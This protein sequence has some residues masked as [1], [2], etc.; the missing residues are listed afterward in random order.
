MAVNPELPPVEEGPGLLTLPPRWKPAERINRWWLTDEATCVQTLLSRCVNDPEMDADITG[1]ATGLVEAVRE[2]RHRKSGIDAFMHEY[3]LSSEEGVVL[4]CLAEA[5]LRIPDADTADRLIADKL[6][7]GHWEEHLGTSESLFV[8]A[9]TWG[10][11][12]TGRLVKPSAET[13]ERPAKF[14]HR[15][16]TRVGEPV[17]RTAMRQAMR[18]MGHQFVMGRDIGEA[19]RRAVKGDNRKYRY[20]YDMLGEAALTTADADAYFDAYSVAIREVGDS[21]TRTPEVVAAPGVSVK[22]S[23]L[24]P[25][26]DFHHREAAVDTLT[27][28]LT[29]LALLARDAGIALT[30]DAE[31]S[32]RLEM[33][34]EVFERVYR[35]PA[36]KGWGGLGVA[37]QAYLKRAPAVLEWLDELAR[38]TGERICVRLVKGA[39]WDSEIKRAQE[40]GLPGYPV[41]TRKINTDVAYL[42]C[43]RQLLAASDLIYPQ[44]A[45]HNAHTV[46]S[47]LHLGKD[48][49]F[50]FQRLHGMGEELYEQ[51]IGAPHERPCR[52]YAPVGRHKDLLPYLVR[53]L[54][55]NG[56]NTSFVNRIVDDRAPVA[57]IIADPVA[58]ARRLE[59]IPHP[60]IPLPRDIYGEQRANSA[61]LN[62][63]DPQVLARLSAGMNAAAEPAPAAPRVAGRERDGEVV[64]SVNPARI[65]E[66]VGE[67]RTA[68]ETLVGE[69]IADAE[70][71]Y[72]E[73]DRVPGETRARHLRQAADL[74]EAHSAELMGLCIREA[75]KTVNDA[76][77][78]VREAI[79]FLRYY[80]MRAE[81]TQF[82]QPE[83]LPGPTGE[84]NEL[85]LGGRG[86]FVCIS[87]WNFPLAIFTGQV[88]AALVAGNCVL[89]KPAEQTSLIAAR[90]VALLHQA[91]IPAR[92]L[93][94]LPGPGRIVGATA[95]ADPRVAGVAFTGSTAT[96][97]GISQALAAR[98][99]PLATL[100]AETGGQNAMLV[101]SSALPE[102]VVIDIVASAFQSAGQRCSALR[103]LYLQK[104]VADR[105]LRILKG[106]MAELVV[107]DPADYRTDVGPVI[108]ESAK[109][110]LEA[111]I[112]RFSSGDGELLYRCRL[113]EACSEGTFVAPAAIEIDGLQRLESE[114]F[115]PV[116]HVVRY[117]S[118]DLDRVIEDINASGYGLTLGVHSRVDHTAKYIASRVRVGNVYIN[119]NQVGAVVGVQP[120]GGRGLSGTGPKAGGPHY[121]PRFACEKVIT[122]NT[123]AV[124]GN[125]SLLALGDD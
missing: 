79:D 118:Q 104:D 116:L 114:M 81:Q 1:T 70:A 110:T 60:R 68:D 55:E 9:S 16:A 5:L 124:G 86:V 107:G 63:S 19:L 105:I 91:G 32:E 80:A 2:N 34:L 62:L 125:A 67:V 102:Q 108:D 120:F 35:D 44:F 51:V 122:N 24:Y 77:A 113:P 98:E 37:V 38:D 20:S 58:A 27:E 57:E 84:R 59:R 54:L 41:Y 12:L 13:R 29:D 100:I 42:A 6:A 82:S 112:A 52:V 28:R 92:A 18:V 15:M 22:L 65:A 21:L 50:E 95:V 76:L 72:P 71:F 97:R 39:Y 17:M 119:R 117:A 23:A 46:A 49:P 48:R 31:E 78:E 14:L 111:H 36:L 43:A 25:R 69:A 103:V 109:Q 106:H 83:L 66:T 26:Y 56:A 8:N 11:M 85:R 90:A 121:L 61:G 75:G 74:Y 53:R 96:A 89:A 30:V 99:G 64:R 87:P 88:C 123:A 101:D 4:M 115:G 73:W 10:M 47:L 3:D 7:A 40:E 93:A 45:T 94:Y 33:S